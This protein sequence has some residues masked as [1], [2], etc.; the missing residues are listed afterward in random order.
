MG[1]FEP[2]LFEQLVT[3]RNPEKGVVKKRISIIPA[4][5]GLHHG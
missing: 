2:W 1:I 3:S 4:I 5:S